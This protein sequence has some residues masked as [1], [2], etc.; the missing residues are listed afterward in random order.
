MVLDLDQKDDVRTILLLFHLFE[1]R[2]RMILRN[3]S[4]KKTIL[5]FR[6]IGQTVCPDRTSVLIH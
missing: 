2:V 4:A 6:L 1:R 3:K 5:E